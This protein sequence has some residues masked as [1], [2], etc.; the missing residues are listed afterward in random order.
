MFSLL[1]AAPTWRW[2]R[3][4]FRWAGKRSSAP[5]K[6]KNSDFSLCF[7]VFVRIRNRS[8]SFSSRIE[9]A[10][11]NASCVFGNVQANKPKTQISFKKQTDF[12]VWLRYVGVF[13]TDYLHHCSSLY[14]RLKRLR[15]A[16][17]HT[18][19][20]NRSCHAWKEEFGHGGLTGLLRVSEAP[21]LATTAVIL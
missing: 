12:V 11:R 7:S 13:S 9:P 20:P 3:S 14:R 17:R 5:N 4:S 10:V 8:H 15:G 6:P 18:W 2:L 16:G 19:A 21:Y 1:L